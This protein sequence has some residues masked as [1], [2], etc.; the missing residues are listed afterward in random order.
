M[1]LVVAGGAVWEEVVEVARVGCRAIMAAVFRVLEAHRHPLGS[2]EI[3]PTLI[4]LL[5]LALLPL[6]ASTAAAAT[7]ATTNAVF[8]G[9]EKIIIL[10]AW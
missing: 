5:E 8:E 4:F 1:L 10:A 6:V 2:C 7:T 3:R 9:F